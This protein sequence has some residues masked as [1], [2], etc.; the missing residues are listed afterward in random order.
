MEMY[1]NII[2]ILEFKKYEYIFEIP[3]MAPFDLGAQMWVRF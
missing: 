3:S 2:G 1:F